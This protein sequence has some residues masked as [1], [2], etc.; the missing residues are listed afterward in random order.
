VAWAPDR[1]PALI[2]AAPVAA[3]PA[4]PAGPS[5]APVT[6]LRRLGSG[7]RGLTEAQAQDRLDQFGE[8]AIAPLR[9]PS[10]PARMLTA[11]RGPFVLVLSGLAVVSAVT[12]DVAGAAVIAALALASCVLR[13]HQEH[14]SDQAAAA[15]RAMVAITATVIRRAA[16]GQPG[17]ARELPVD[18]LV[19]GDIV[20]LAPGDLVPADLVLLR[21]AGLMVSQAVLTGES[22]PAAKTAADGRLPGL[23]GPLTAASGVQAPH[24]CF[25]GTSV[26]SG[27]GRGVVVTTGASTYLGSV[28]RDPRP[29]AETTFD[30]GVRSIAWVLVGFMLVCV[31][32]VLV[33]NAAL[34]GH[35]LEALLFGVAVAV[36]LTPEMLPVVI[37][38]VLA[39]G[40]GRMAGRSAIVKR[41][42]AIHNIGAMDVLCTD[43]TGTLTEDLITLDRAVDPAGHD[44]PR[45]LHWA[46]LA[47]QALAEAAGLTADPL[48]LALIE[49]AGPAPDEGHLVTGLV[50]FDAG[51][52]R[53]TAVLR[54]VAEPGR[55]LL[56]TQG[57]PEAVLDCCSRV[58]ADGRELELGPEGRQR[59]A[60]LARHCAAAGVR[61]L[62]V[63]VT[64]RPARL[65]RYRPADEAGLTLAGFVGFRDQPRESAGAALAELAAAGVRVKVITGDHPDVA[66]HVCRQVGIDPGVPLTG[67]EIAC[68]DDAA[69]A[70]LAARG[71]VFA[72]VDPAQKARIVRALRAAGHTVGFLGD[73][74]NDVAALRAA[75]VG[76][77]VAGAM[78][79]AREHA[80][81][82]LLR[83]DLRAVGQAVRQGRRAFGNIAKYLKITV[84][85]NLGNVASMVLASAA[86]PFLPMLPIQVL[87]QNLCFDGCQLALAFDTVDEA[88]VARP[89]SFDAR[90]LTR[91]ALL[92]GPVNMVA[93]LAT[94]GVLWWLAGGHATPAAAALLRTGWLT[95]NLLTQAAA[96]HLLRSR[97]RPSRRH[98]AARP[99]LLATVALVVV[100]LVLPVTPLAAGLGLRALPLAFFPLLAVIVAAYCLATSAAKAACLRGRSL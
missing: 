75:D 78:A 17:T 27:S 50:P 32:V 66:A 49:Q 85:A 30:R 55:D 81:V 51:R 47:S 11:A 93:D 43:K 82:I 7:P 40:A 68:V 22:Q 29:A 60:E 90:D 58:L 2:G 67:P 97:R 6:V 41:L 48:D 18:Q 84:S 70:V 57:A 77:S 64:G 36:G 79:A 4:G 24:L 26:V 39:R 87:V 74:L 42:P 98:R 69:L 15:L 86:L 80:D 54:A 1:Q 89:R 25:L 20:D 19:P 88:E 46:L 65:G 45:V 61:L 8:N 62:A 5:A 21:S 33:L 28:Q 100:A 56:I 95:E 13:M 34:R 73:G 96:V 16:V 83:K 37:T 76:I 31:P 53:A 63:A 91:F 12:G 59:A 23:P 44:D 94:F 9:Q 38:T 99:V 52:R 92:I 72:R 35:P 3:G 10:W 14:R 71:T